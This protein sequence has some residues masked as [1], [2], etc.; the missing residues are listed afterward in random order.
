MT[1]DLIAR[2][3]SVREK[4][5][6][7]DK[8]VTSFNVTLI[9]PDGPKAADALEAKDK[10]IAELKTALDDAMTALIKSKI[11]DPKLRD[12]IFSKISWQ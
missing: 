3:R 8:F 7:G 11:S 1:D 2:L 6:K 9:N 12:A 4:R 5:S 10:L